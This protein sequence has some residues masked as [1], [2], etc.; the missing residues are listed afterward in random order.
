MLSAFRPSL[1]VMSHVGVGLTTRGPPSLIRKTLRTCQ[2][3]EEPERA[4]GA[5][6]LEARKPIPHIFSRGYASPDVSGRKDARASVVKTIAQM[7][8]AKGAP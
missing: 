8:G 6:G 5:V 1:H 2:W 7:T 4:S 3:E